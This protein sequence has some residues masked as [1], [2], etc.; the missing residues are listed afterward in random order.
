MTDKDYEQRILEALDPSAETEHD[1]RVREALTGGEWLYGLEPPEY[2]Y[3]DAVRGW[4][5]TEGLRSAA[6]RYGRA[7]ATKG[8]SRL[9]DDRVA[10]IVQETYALTNPEWDSLTRLER[11]AEILNRH[12]ARFEAL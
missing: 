10:G 1:K 7:G 2:D 12:A 6:D 11:T 8:A 3:E 9:S 4:A 5:A